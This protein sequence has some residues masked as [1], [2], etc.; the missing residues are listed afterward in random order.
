MSSYTLRPH[1][2]KAIDKIRDAFRRGKRTP[3]L[4][5][6]TGFGKTLVSI[7]IIKSAL[8][9]S[10][11][12]LFIVDRI[13]LIDQTSEEFDFH[14]LDHGVIQGDHWRVNNLPLQLASVQTLARR[15]NKPNFDLI[16][17]DECHSTNKALTELI[18]N[19]WNAL[20]FIGLSATPFT[21]GL[22]KIYDDLIVVE[23]TQSLIDK[24]FLA[25]FVAYGAVKLNLEGV[26]TVAG[27]YNQKQIAEKVNTKTI[28]GDVVDT[29]LRR[30]ENRQ[31]ICFCVNIA[32]AEAVADEFNSNGVTAG[33]ICSHTPPEER[34]QILEDYEAG[35][36]KVLCNVEVF[37]KGWDSPN[38][39]CLILARPT[40]S[41]MLYIQMVGRVLR[42][43][44]GKANAIIL[45]HGRNI[46]RLG[47]P[48]DEL[49]E[50]LCNGE[51]T[52]R[53]KQ[54][55]QERKEVLPKPCPNCNFMK[56]SFQCP[57]CG[58]K[59][60]GDPNVTAEHGELK[61][62]ERVTPNEKAEWFAMLLGYARSKGKQDGY[63][64]YLFKDKF[65]HFPHKKQ[66]VRAKEP[67]KEVTGFITHL[68]IKKSKGGH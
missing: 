43:A 31:T 3:I 28:I 66:G 7:D 19:S 25:D 30:G 57:S 32:H 55:E 34:E 27:D 5:A 59:P 52:E 6:S 61:K 58:H 45:D 15:R 4:Q 63:A 54:K 29:W 21:K 11:R 60:A 48:T 8:A 2:V 9:K 10:K 56:T 22:G 24:G 53:E 35:D 1:Q 39:S 42:T 47:F 62:L 67:T 12:V 41:L 20:P 37:T 46:E 18:T 33:M 14:G 26:A 38:T 17:V 51:K 16:I 13:K 36:I 64:A 44:E 49:P 65:G 23:T 50:Y 68:N 40:K